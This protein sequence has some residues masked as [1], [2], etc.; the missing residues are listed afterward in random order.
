MGDDRP[1]RE[2]EAT[3]RR[4]GLS[5]SRCRRGSRVGRHGEA[6]GESAGV[7][8][9]ARCEEKSRHG[10]AKPCDKVGAGLD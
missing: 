3:Y 4:T 6:I 1:G 10:I 7:H 9:S 2:Q 8:V 5:A